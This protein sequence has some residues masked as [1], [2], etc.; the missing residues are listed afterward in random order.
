[1]EKLVKITLTQNKG[2]ELG[3]EARRKWE[4]LYRDSSLHLPIVQTLNTYQLLQS[5]QQFWQ[6]GSLSSLLMIYREGSHIK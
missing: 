6:V 1:M 4:E 2:T 5:A 3:E